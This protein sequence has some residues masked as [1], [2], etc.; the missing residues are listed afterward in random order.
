MRSEAKLTALDNPDPN[1]PLIYTRAPDGSVVGVEAEVEDR[2]RDRQDGELKWREVMELRFLRGD[3]KD[4]EYEN[5]DWND[6]FDDQDEDRRRGLE[7]YLDEEVEEF[8]G[9]GSSPAG[10]TGVQDF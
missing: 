9:D 4:F 10:E 6:E 3:D 1:S 2:A 8:V 5:V 7:E